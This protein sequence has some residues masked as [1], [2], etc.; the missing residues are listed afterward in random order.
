MIR[1]SKLF[2]Y[3][4]IL[5]LVFTIIGC[6]N[7]GGSGQQTE[8]YETLKVISVNDVH[9]TIEESSDNYGFAGLSWYVNNERSKDGQAV[10]VLAAGDMF[11]GTAIANYTYGENVI[12]LMNTIGFDAMTIGNHEF[13]WGLDTVLEYVDGKKDNG[14]ADFPFLACNL[15]EKS[16][17]KIPENVEA[18]TV[19]DYKQ[20]QVGVIGYIGPGIE[21]DI[22]A[23]YVE[24]YEFVDPVDYISQ[25][26]HELRTEKGCD[27]VIVMGHADNSSLNTRIAELKGDH[28][29]DM[30]V[31]GHSHAT[32]TKTLRNGNNK[33]IPVVQ[34]GSAGDSLTDTEFQLN[35]TNDIFGEGLA[36]TVDLGGYDILS[37]KKVADMVKQM[38]NEIAPI[39]GEELGVAGRNV[40]KTTVGY[41]S[42]SAILNHVKCD[43]AAINTGGIRAYAFPIEEGTS[44]TVKKM[45]EIMP[46][47]NFIKTCKLTGDKL[48]AVLNINDLFLSEN[49]IKNGIEWY[50]N[51]EKIDNNKVY[52]F[53][54]VDYLFDR[55]EEI[56]GEGT[57]I[58]FTGKL[59]RD[60]MIEQ[61]RI[62]S[63][64]N[65]PW[66]N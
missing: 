60:I 55:D 12:K 61:L 33:M 21:S 18:Y 2:N 3:I 5:F 22:S 34:S 47:D 48:K 58:I 1:I 8:K 54:C 17:N 38:A 43:L 37:D 57:D 66:L 36:T 39:M 45:Y 35:G 52:T 44:I 63:K 30:L 49:V 15:I 28:A 53:A 6:G 50:I 26:S 19:V 40:T 20:F 65:L 32:Y 27:M 24:D 11:Q 31:N 41:W 13:D 64:N 4:L 62:D 46:F 42:A 29:V 14:E 51:G 59:M 25:L 9:G 23:S 10:L 7:T 56:Y 16:T